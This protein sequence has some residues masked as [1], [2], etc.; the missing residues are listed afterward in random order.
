MSSVNT[1]SIIN[2]DIVNTNRQNDD[3]VTKMNN[4]LSPLNTIGGENGRK[5]KHINPVEVNVIEYGKVDMIC[6][7]CQIKSIAGDCSKCGIYQ[8]INRLDLFDIFIRRKQ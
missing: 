4:G 8:Y 2:K 5:E 7:Q 6:D 1:E 3:G